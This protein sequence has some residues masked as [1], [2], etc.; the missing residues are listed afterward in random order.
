LPRAISKTATGG[1]IDCLDPGGIGTVTIV[2]S[3]TLD[4]RETEG[5]ILAWGVTDV[6]VNGADISVILCGR[7]INGAGAS[8]GTTR[9]RILLTQSVTIEDSYIFDFGTRG[10]RGVSV[11]RAST[12]SATWRR[13]PV[14]AS[15]TNTSTVLRT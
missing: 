9:V 10:T 2:K 8:P 11:Y 7:S 3:I 15:W 6:A 5:S 14:R 12:T 13:P 4:R 1:E